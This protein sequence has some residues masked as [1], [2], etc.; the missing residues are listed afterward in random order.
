MGRRWGIIPTRGVYQGLAFSGALTSGSSPLARGLRGPSPPACLDLGIIPARAGFTATR[1]SRSRVRTDHPRSR[2]V[3]DELTA[4]G[5]T[6]EGSSPLARGLPAI[7]RN[8]VDAK[9]IIP[10]RA[11]F[12]R[13]RENTPLGPGDHPRSRGVYPGANRSQIAYVGSSPLARGLRARSQKNALRQ[14]IIPARAGF[15]IRRARRF[16]SSADHPRSRGVYPLYFLNTPFLSG[17]SPLARGLLLR[18]RLLR[19]SGGIIPARAGFTRSPAPTTTGS[20]DHPRSRGVYCGGRLCSPERC[21]SS[22]LARGLRGRMKVKELL[23]GIIPARAGFTPR[24]TKRLR[25]YR[26]HPRSRGVYDHGATADRRCRGSSPLA[27]GLPRPLGVRQ[28]PPGIIPARAG[29]T[30]QAWGAFR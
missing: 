28:A 10:A 29:F 18:L 6:V 20:G 8:E 25:H 9:R 30:P 4:R 24:H 13:G 19:H 16:G 26:D 23:D 2:G 17:S 5:A 15:T 21:G 27:R 3:Y 14:G 7:E 1:R 12:T 22:P 11:G